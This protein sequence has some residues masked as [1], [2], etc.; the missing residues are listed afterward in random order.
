MLFDESKEKRRTGAKRRN[1]L[2]IGS[3]SSNKQR[4]RE[5]GRER[6][7]KSFNAALARRG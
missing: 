1:E 6:E 5:R 7:P 2:A 3:R 4:E